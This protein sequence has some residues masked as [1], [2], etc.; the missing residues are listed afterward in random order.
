MS[1]SSL[2]SITQ[3]KKLCNRK[4]HFEEMLLCNL[5]RPT[6]GVLST[7]SPS[8]DPLLVHEKAQTG[9]DGFEGA[10]EL[11]PASFNPK[12]IQPEFSGKMLVLDYILAVT[13]A[14]TN[15]KV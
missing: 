5:P 9:E 2:S 7:L 6:T 3:L 14:T 1:A 8:P 13:R 10:L 15:D 4:N 12:T 11:F